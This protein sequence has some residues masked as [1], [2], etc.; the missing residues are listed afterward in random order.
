MS[1]AAGLPQ[2]GSPTRLRIGVE[3]RILDWAIGRSGK[4]VEILSRD[5]RMKRIREWL[6]GESRPTLRQLERF[7]DA[8][9]TPLGYLFLSEPPAEKM[10]VPYFRTAGAG[11]ASRPSLDLI[12]TVQ[13]VKQRQDWM[14]DH[15]VGEGN[16]PL[17]F[18]GSARPAD[19]PTQVAREMRG[20]LGMTGEW[21]AN[22]DSWEDALR[23]LR[24]GMEEAGVFVVTNGI[25]GY[26]TR[27]ALQVDEFRGF[28][29]VD[30]YAPFVFVNGADAK[31]AQMFTLAHELAHVWLGRSAA[32]DLHR[33]DPADDVTERA[34][35][36]IAAEF[37]VPEKEMRRAWG[38]LAG[39][40][41]PYRDAA[42]HF[43]VS[44]LVVARR[45]FDLGLIGRNVFLG[46]YG[47]W[48]KPDARSSGGGNFYASANFRVGRRFASTVINAARG[49]RILYREAY[50][51]TGLNRSSFEKYAA[52]LGLGRSR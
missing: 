5:K 7:A 43:K 51:L 36:R 48:Y 31:A 19:P 35:N 22:L 50:R 30:D 13:T 27:R 40:S 34:C 23:A 4:S 44:R 52:S 46:L 37:L 47:Q 1:G 45:A 25:V 15:L 17:A 41:D 20:A 9:F 3:R 38:R 14:R 18:V 33:L 10:P 24:D 29:L 26:N 39:R 28:V 42:R 2:P 49:E 11:P 16:D 21:T 12:E 6:S 8:T 32:F